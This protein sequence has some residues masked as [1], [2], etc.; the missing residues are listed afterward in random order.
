M[1]KAGLAPPL[2][3]NARPPLQEKSQRAAG[4]DAGREQRE[5]SRSQ[6]AVLGLSN[7]SV[8]PDPLSPCAVLQNLRKD[9]GLDGRG[10]VEGYRVGLEGRLRLRGGSPS[11]VLRRR[12]WE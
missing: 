8:V 11:S 3:V 12:R 7:G 4:C 2:R 9:R 10:L 5:R 6:K 1:D